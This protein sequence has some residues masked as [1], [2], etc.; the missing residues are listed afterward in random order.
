M[1]RAP[2]KTVI[3]R[4]L[5]DFLIDFFIISWCAH[6]TLTPEDRRRIVFRRGILIGLNDL[7]D[8]GGHLCPS[9]TEGEILL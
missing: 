8:E 3:A 4:A 7:I 1:N 6:V 9:S 2:N 5:L